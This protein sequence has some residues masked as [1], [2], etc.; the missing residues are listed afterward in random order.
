MGGLGLGLSLG[1]VLGLGLVLVLLVPASLPPSL[2]GVSSLR[3]K[4]PISRLTSSSLSESEESLAIRLNFALVSVNSLSILKSDFSLFLFRFLGLCSAS[5]CRFWAF[6]CTLW[7]TGTSWD[8]N[9]SF[10]FGVT[11]NV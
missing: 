8:V 10:V 6:Q 2:R 4:S 1:L 7:C 9:R 5:L 3:D 11:V